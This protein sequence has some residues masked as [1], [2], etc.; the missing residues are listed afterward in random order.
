LSA[1]DSE[2]FAGDKAP[3]LPEAFRSEEVS[4]LKVAELATVRKGVASNIYKAS[5]GGAFLTVLLGV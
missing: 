3:F 5:L 1:L 2:S 4:L